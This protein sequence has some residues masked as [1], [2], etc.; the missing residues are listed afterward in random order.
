VGRD[1]QQVSVPPSMT[2][3]IPVVQLD[4][5]LALLAINTVRIEIAIGV[6]G[7]GA[8]LVWWRSD[9]EL[10]AHRG[11]R[12]VPDAIFAVNGLNAIDQVFAL[13]VEYGTRAPRGL[14]KKLLRYRTAQYR[15]D[16]IF[17]HGDPI[18]LVVSKDP[19]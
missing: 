6:D 1:L 3:S 15:R 2:K 18:V 11:Q 7:A 8:N 14:Q 9:W 13:E 5:A 17:R 4:S 12:T 10:R 16:G 19:K